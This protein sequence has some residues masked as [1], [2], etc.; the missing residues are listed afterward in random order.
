MDY[1]LIRAWC[2]HV[3]E[4]QR[5]TRDLVATAHED[6]APTNAI[7]KNEDG[8]WATIEDVASPIPRVQIE[9]IAE[10]IMRN[11]NPDHPD[12]PPRQIT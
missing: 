5:F 9:R 8:T 7:F 4:E 10:R 3:G 11:E 2:Q 6:K 12:L 1:I